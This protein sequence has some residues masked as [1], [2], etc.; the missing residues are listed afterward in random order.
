MDIT[1]EINLD[2]TAIHFMAVIMWFLDEIFG[3]KI[4]LIE[5]SQSEIN[6]K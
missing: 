4:A 3:S 6:N 1:T 5:A 2:K